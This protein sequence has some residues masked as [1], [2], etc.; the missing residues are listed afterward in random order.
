MRS[1]HYTKDCVEFH[2]E[3][4]RDSYPAVNVKVYHFPTVYQIIDKIPEL[5]DMEDQ[6]KAETLAEQAGEYAFNAMCEIFWNENAQMIADDHFPEH[7]KVYSEGRS[8][9]WLVVH[10][11]KD[12]SEWDAIDLRRWQGFE[13][14]IKAEVKYLTSLDY[15]VDDIVANQWYLPYAEEFNFYDGKDGQI[16]CIAVEKAKLVEDYPFIK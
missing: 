5:K 2:N 8:N 3:S 11:L 16:H 6:D 1:K 9:G 7:V 14:A 12:F 13:N 15:V 10:G 4:Y